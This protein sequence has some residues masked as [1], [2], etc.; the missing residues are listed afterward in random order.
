MWL[1][2]RAGDMRKQYWR[3]QTE[4]PMLDEVEYEQ[5]TG[6][7][8]GQLSIAKWQQTQL[9]AY[10]HMT[11]YR[12]YNVNALFHHRLSLY[13]PPCPKCAKPLRTSRA[14]FCAYCGDGVPDRAD[15][16]S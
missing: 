2:V 3:C 5:L 1:E 11:G 10:E 14:T 6:L 9:D 13:G 16:P 12:E 4:L 7:G 8:R 15:K